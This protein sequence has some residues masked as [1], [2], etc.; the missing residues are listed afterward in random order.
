MLKR[1]A[2]YTA[3]VTFGIVL[4]LDAQPQ[5]SPVQAPA[6]KRTILQR[7]DVPGTNLELIFATVDIAA[8]ARAGRHTHPGLTMAQVVEGDFWQVLHPGDSS[9]NPNRAIHDE[10]ALDKPVKLSAVYVV[11]KG[12]PLAMP[13]Q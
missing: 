4:S 6:F 12:K 11:E 8:G 2:M 5:P 13:V 7:A 3:L 10:G 1:V 9:S